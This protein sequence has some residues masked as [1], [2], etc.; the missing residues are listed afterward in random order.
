MKPPFWLKLDGPYEGPD[1]E[2]VF[3]VRIPWWG[4]PFA[5]LDEIRSRI[6]GSR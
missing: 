3:T 1:G 5:Y 4:W 6:R 2:W